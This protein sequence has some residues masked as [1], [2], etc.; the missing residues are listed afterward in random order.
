MDP[1]G[2]VIAVMPGDSE[3][4][5]WFA[6]VAG[7][8]HKLVNSPDGYTWDELR[9]HI[10]ADSSSLNGAYGDALIV[11]LEKC[12]GINQFKAMCEKFGQDFPGAYRK[13]AGEAWNA[14]VQRYAGT[15]AN[16]DYSDEHWV[17]LR[18]WFYGAA[19]SV[20]PTVL[21]MARQQLTPLDSLP[22]TD[23]THYLRHFG[24]TATDPVQPAASAQADA[25]TQWAS[26]VTAHGPQWVGYDGSEDG[27]VPFRD[28]FYQL[29]GQNFPAAATIAHDKLSVL[30]GVSVEE[31]VGKLRGY[32]FTIG[33]TAPPV[34]EL[35]P[36]ANAIRI[37]NAKRSNPPGQNAKGLLGGA[38]F[39]AATLVSMAEAVATTS[40][41][42]R[43][44][45][46]G[47]AS[48]CVIVGA[49]SGNQAKMV[50]VDETSVAADIGPVTGWTV[51]LASQKFKHLGVDPEFSDKFAVKIVNDLV[52]NGANIVA[53]YSTDRL[54]LSAD[55]RV[56]A[57]F[58]PSELQEMPDPLPVEVDLS[59][60]V[61][62]L[63]MTICNLLGDLT[64]ELAEAVR[65]AAPSGDTY[66]VEAVPSIDWGNPPTRLAAI[67]ATVRDAE[68]MLKVLDGKV[69]PERAV[70]RTKRVKEQIRKA[71]RENAL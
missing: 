69:L 64:P 63:R 45:W 6:I 15:W 49:H 8:H 68:E 41:S 26:A 37:I 48:A 24:F 20:H 46:S 43:V 19:G 33:Y 22:A 66:E 53:V 27:W 55:G 21:A 61:R 2:A 56:S 32:G 34:R 12:G 36:A 57:Q 16:W 62:H 11:Y 10:A 17:T 38:A 3:I 51:Y 28:W 59:V 65:Q 42:C 29:I 58:H 9:K 71:K 70:N 25:E 52:N 18:D 35:D 31:R 4:D 44:V 23:R 47:G 60:N 39:S 1:E 40:E 7:V 67:V 54:A 30:D 5:R 13:I 50:H 14:T